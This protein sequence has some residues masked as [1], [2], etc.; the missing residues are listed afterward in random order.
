MSDENTF[1][2]Q[3]A[4]EFFQHMLEVMTRAE[5]AAGARLGS[6]ASSEASPEP[7]SACLPVAVG[8]PH[9][10]QP[11]WLLQLPHRSH[12]HTVPQHPCRQRHQQGRAQRLQGDRMAALFDGTAKRRGRVG[13]ADRYSI[14]A[15][16]VNEIER[17][18]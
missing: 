13:A 17:C 6:D 18:T 4:E 14:A 16:A 12:Q 1:W 10:L 7:H 2:L 8:G 5:R 11:V 3:D 15:D 9:P